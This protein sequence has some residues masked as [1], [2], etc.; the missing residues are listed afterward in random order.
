[1]NIGTKISKEGIMFAKLADI[2][3]KIEMNAKDN[4]FVTLKVHKKTFQ[5]ISYYKAHGNTRMG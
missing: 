5:E 2:V 1:M 4:S 3:D